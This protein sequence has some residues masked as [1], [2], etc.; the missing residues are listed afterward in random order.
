MKPR[1]LP[2]P[3][4]PD[5]QWRVVSGV[6]EWCGSD[7]PLFFELLDSIYVRP[8]V[9]LCVATPERVALWTDLMLNPNEPV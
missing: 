8:D 7:V 2:D 4:K 3:H 1:V 5:Y 9:D 6:R